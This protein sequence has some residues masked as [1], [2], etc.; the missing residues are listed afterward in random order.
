MI[1]STWIGDTDAHN[2]IS[3]T[4]MATPHVSGV[5][6]MYFAHHGSKTPAQA[7]A[8]LQDVA[9]EGAIDSKTIGA[10][11]PNLLLYSPFA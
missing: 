10:G 8:W 4:S 2:V 6:A 11:S 5:V 3:G 7:V 1:D 9:T